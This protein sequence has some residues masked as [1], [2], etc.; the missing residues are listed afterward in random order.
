MLCISLGK[1]FRYNL[2]GSALSVVDSIRDFGVMLCSDLSFDE[3]VRQIVCHLELLV[4]SCDHLS[5]LSILY[6][7]IAL[8]FACETNIRICRSGIFNPLTGQI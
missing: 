7:E 5:S 1:D 8:L 4:L 6:V 3:H 2:E